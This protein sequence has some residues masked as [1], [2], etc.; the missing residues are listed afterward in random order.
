MSVQMGFPKINIHPYG[1]NG[2]N[3]W[4]VLYSIWNS[5]QSTIGAQFTLNQ[6]INKAPDTNTNSNT[7][8]PS[9]IFIIRHGEKNSSSLPNYS[10][11]N[12]GIYIVLVN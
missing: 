10:L 9:N 7:I 1:G 2:V 6:D 3:A 12:N 11:N 8:G 4:E 5:Y